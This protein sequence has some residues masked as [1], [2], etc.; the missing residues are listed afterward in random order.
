MK[1]FLS[2]FKFTLPAL[3]VAGVFYLFATNGGY[4]PVFKADSEEV[5]SFTQN[6]EAILPPPRAHNV[7]FVV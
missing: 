1:N 2:A 3:L 6:K 4:E 7:K 5:T